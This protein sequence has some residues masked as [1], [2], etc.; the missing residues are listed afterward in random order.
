MLF[1][2]FRYLVFF[3]VVFTVYWTLRSNSKRKV[4]LLGASYLFYGSWD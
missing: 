2:E 3:A 1:T 4:W